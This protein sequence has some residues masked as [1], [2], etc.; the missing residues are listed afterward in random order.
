MPALRTPAFSSS[1]SAAS[2]AGMRS[3]RGKE[4]SPSTAAWRTGQESSATAR[5]S[6]GIA[7]ATPERASSSTTPRRTDSSP[8]RSEASALAMSRVIPSP[9]LN[10]EH[11]DEPGEVL[12]LLGEVGGGLRHLLHGGEVV[13][14]DLGDVLHG[15]HHEL[16]ALLLLGGGVRDLL[17]HVVHLLHRVH[18]LPAPLRLLL[19]R[20]P[21]LGGDLV[22]VLDGEAHLAPPRRLLARGVG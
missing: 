2:S 6:G 13:P 22:D 3:S 4:V 11:R 21:H 19:G 5:R 16:A 10:P 1:R 14:G 9:L 17:G 20:D 7:S 18:D 8:S 15:P 12:R